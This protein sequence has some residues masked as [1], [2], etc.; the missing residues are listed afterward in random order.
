ML[1]RSLGKIQST[2]AVLGV[3]IPII[4]GRIDKREGHLL[5]SSLGFVPSRFKDFPLFIRNTPT[6]DFE[7]SGFD[8]HWGKNRHWR[9]VD[10]KFN[11]AAFA[12][13]QA[14]AFRFWQDARR[15]QQKQR[16]LLRRLPESLTLYASPNCTGKH[17]D[18]CSISCLLKTLERAWLAAQDDY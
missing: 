6:G 10:W 9:L 4:G 16:S 2:L 13:T 5:A 15:C 7:V 11:Y 3:H 17:S 18:E 1:F 8:R 14:G 12:K